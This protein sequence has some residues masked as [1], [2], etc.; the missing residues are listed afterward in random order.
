MPRRSRDYRVFM[1]LLIAGGVFDFAWRLLA[2]VGL[3][4][5]ATLVAI[6]SVVISLVAFG[7]LFFAVAPR[8]ARMTTVVG[9]SAAFSLSLLACWIIQA[10]ELARQQQCVDNLRRIG[11]VAREQ[12]GLYPGADPYRQPR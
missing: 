4:H 8:L 10:R 2:L 1:A 12:I 11:M 3:G 7:C 6:A 5:L 9:F